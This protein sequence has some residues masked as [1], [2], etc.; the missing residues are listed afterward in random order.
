M[1]LVPC[2]C[3]A[4]YEKL[5]MFGFYF[6]VGID[7]GA[8][9]VVYAVAATNKRAA[10]IFAGYAAAVSAYGRPQAVRADMAFEAIP[11]GQDMLDHRGPGSFLVGPSTANQVLPCALLEWPSSASMQKHPR[12]PGRC[13]DMKCIAASSVLRIFGISSGHTS[14]STTASCLRKWR[15][16]ACWTGTQ[17]DAWPCALLD[18]AIASHDC[19]CCAGPATPC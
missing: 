11:V 7:G 10:T 13:A 6:H 5:K 2:L 17:A 16:R 14:H 8:N 1:H 4:A 3:C 9:F 15:P 12:L 19:T 18:L